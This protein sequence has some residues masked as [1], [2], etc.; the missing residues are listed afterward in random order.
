MNNKRPTMGQSVRAMRQATK[1][2]VSF[3]YEEHGVELTGVTTEWIPEY[4]DV[5]DGI[6]IGYRLV[7]SGVSK[8]Q[9]AY[10][11]DYK[12]WY[13]FGSRIFKSTAT[14]EVWLVVPSEHQDPIYVF[15]EDVIWKGQPDD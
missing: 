9:T 10:D 6:Y 5:Y 3:D 4:K 8:Q 2:H 7:H 12:T 15:P 1:Q 11:S 14:H 13:T